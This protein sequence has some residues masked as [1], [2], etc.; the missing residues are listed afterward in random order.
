MRARTLLVAAA[1]VVGLLLAGGILAAYLMGQ[2]EPD[3]GASIR[4]VRVEEAPPD[5]RLLN[6]T[7]ADVEGFPSRLRDAFRTAAAE[8]EARVEATGEERAAWRA[9]LQRAEA[10]AG[11]P[12]QHYAFRGVL[13]AAQEWNP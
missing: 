6:L 2:V 9:A 11:G 1:S 5:V 4:I 3:N 7:E 10:E 13:L 8:G 12:S